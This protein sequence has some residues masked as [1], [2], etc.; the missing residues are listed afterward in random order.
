MDLPGRALDDAQLSAEF[1]AQGILTLAP[2]SQTGMVNVIGHSQG[3]G[4]NI[5]WVSRFARPAASLA[6]QHCRLTSR[7]NAPPH[8]PAP[9]ALQFFPSTQPLVQNYIALAGDFKGTTLSVGICS[10]AC[11]ASVHQQTAG[12]DYLGVQADQA[13]VPTTSI[14][15]VQDEVIQ[16]ETG[17]N[18]TSDLDGASVIAVQD[19]AFCGADHD[20]S[21]VE[22]T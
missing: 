22:M 11:A 14:F 15:T 2:Q 6:S 5:Q 18:P 7:S 10:I 8:S 3:A 16:P 13:L 17:R 1:V 19:E 9:Q 20:A 12:S 4:L 21:H